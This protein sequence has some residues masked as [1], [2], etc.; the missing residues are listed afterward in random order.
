LGKLKRENEI[1]NTVKRVPR[2]KNI[3]EK[4]LEQPV[5][6]DETELKK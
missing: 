4:E 2:D 3:I 5:N 1:Q 6:F